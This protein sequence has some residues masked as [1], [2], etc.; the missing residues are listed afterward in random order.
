MPPELHFDLAGIDFNCIVADREAIRQVNPQRYELEQLDAVIAERGALGFNCKILLEMA[1]EVGSVGLRQVCEQHHDGLLKADILIASDGPRLSP[2][3][4][5]LFLG[6]RGLC[7]FDLEIEARE[8]AHHSG[9]WGGLLSDPAIQLAHAIA[10]ITTPT[11]EI[12]IP[13]WKPNHLPEA[14]R[15][16]LVNCEIEAGPGAPEIDPRWGEP[17]LSRA[18]QVFG[19]S[20]FDV[21][22]MTAGNP[23]SPVN[24][25]P[26]C[27]TA[28]R[29]PAW[30]NAITSV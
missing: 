13:E 5:T 24:A 21:L 8:G 27:A 17:G 6:A 4:P 9:N 12:R 25:V 16:A 2:N 3:A 26:I 14:V 29:M 30:W 19:W 10:S 20:S 11:G 23:D 15:E 18:E 7:N 22:A 28:L 1:E